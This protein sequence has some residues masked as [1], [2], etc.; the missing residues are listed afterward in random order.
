MPVLAV[1]LLSKPQTWLIWI[2]AI[3]KGNGMKTEVDPDRQQ[4]S[5]HLSSKQEPPPRL[6]LLVT[7]FCPGVK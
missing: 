5:P 3:V 1:M 6:S 4:I 2:T 7:Q